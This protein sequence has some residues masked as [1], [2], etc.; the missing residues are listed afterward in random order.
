MESPIRLKLPEFVARDDSAHMCVVYAVRVPFEWLYNTRFPR[1]QLA[2]WL[3]R[4]VFQNPQAARI[5]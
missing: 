5:P 2:L 3:A 1:L 4:L